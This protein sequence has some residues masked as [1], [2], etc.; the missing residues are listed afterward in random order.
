MNGITFLRSDAVTNPFDDE[1]A[2]YVVLANAEE[3]HSL[4]PSS[5][6]VPSGWSV[7]HEAADRAAC[8]NYVERNWTDMRPASLRG[9]LA[10][11]P[12]PAA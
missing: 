3:Q 5:A 2:S 1:N 7:V 9:E 10:G 8:L 6:P 11:T 4:W 12:S